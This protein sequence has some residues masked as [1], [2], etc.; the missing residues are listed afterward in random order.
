MPITRQLAATLKHT[1]RRLFFFP[2]GVRLGR[3]SSIGRP[4]IVEGSSR[5]H[6]GERTT[7]LNGP[8]LSAIEQ[9]AGHS[10]QPRIEIGDDVYIGHHC[11]LTAIDAITI[12]SGCVLSEYVYITDFMHGFRPDRG[13]IMQQPLESKGP[14]QIGEHTFLGY[15]VS[16][17][18]GVTLG[19]HCIVGAHSVVTHSFPAYSMIAGSP[20]RLLKVYSPSTETWE[21][22]S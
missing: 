10:H 8:W 3:Q 12:A 1:V 2:R 4:W 22:V 20:A 14:V 16:V 6:I 11:C 15:R 9:Y 21:P 18:P 17:M 13:L 19:A 7:I 5:I